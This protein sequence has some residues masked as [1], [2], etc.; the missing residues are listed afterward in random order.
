[1]VL[2]YIVGQMVDHIMDNILMIKN[3]EQ[4]NIY[5]QMVDIMKEN[6]K[7]VNN[8]EKENMFY[9]MENKNKV[10]GIK[11]EELNGQKILYKSYDLIK[12]S[13]FFIMRII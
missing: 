10:Y 5:G 13:F 2:E 11:E 1:M 12:K 6:G 3:K 9:L 4:G 8:M 7:M